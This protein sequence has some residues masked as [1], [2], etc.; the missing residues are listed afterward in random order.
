MQKWFTQRH[1]AADKIETRK[2]TESEKVE[3]EEETR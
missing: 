3:K 2:K 1:K